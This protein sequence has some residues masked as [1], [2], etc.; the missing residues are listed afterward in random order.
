MGVESRRISK[1]GG[2][3]VAPEDGVTRDRKNRGDKMEARTRQR[4]REAGD[5][6]GMTTRIARS[7]SLGY[8][9]AVLGQCKLNESFSP[10]RPRIPRPS[11]YSH[12]RR[13]GHRNPDASRTE[14]AAARHPARCSP[15]VQQHKH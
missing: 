10:R 2:K 1:V 6:G 11:L 3:N 12:A 13:R 9:S 14:R 15:R 4:G 7:Y 5:K 8:N